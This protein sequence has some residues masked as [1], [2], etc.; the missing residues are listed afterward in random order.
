MT[1]RAVR[2][3]EESSTSGNGPTHTAITCASQCPPPNAR[4]QKRTAAKQVKEGKGEK[5]ERERELVWKY[6]AKG[7][8]ERQ[9]EK[10]DQKAAAMSAGESTT[11]ANVLYGLRGWRKKGPRARERA[12]TPLL[13]SNGGPGIQAS[14][15]V[16]GAIGG[17]DSKE[18]KEGSRHLGKELVKFPAREAQP[19]KIGVTASTSTSS[20]FRC[21]RQ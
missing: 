17:Q 21:W 16:N 7:K 20:S 10:V 15:P 11:L 9:W 13:R 12:G 18:E 3:K 19:A 2:R 1:R 8:R 6:T 14:C 5:R 4:G